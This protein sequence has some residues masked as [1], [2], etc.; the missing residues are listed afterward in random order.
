VSR[1]GNWDTPQE[2]AAKARERA[3]IEAA[4]AA[5]RRL[6][7]LRATQRLQAAKRLDAIDTITDA[8]GGELPTIIAEALRQ[9][10]DTSQQIGA[11]REL[12]RAHQTGQAGSSRPPVEPIATPAR[13]PATG[14]AP[15]VYRSG[16]DREAVRF[17]PSFCEG[18]EAAP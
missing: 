8:L 15:S 10:I 3:Q 18:A 14:R 11:H 5:R 4:A 1:R 9:V 16:I 17:G 12:I 6:R 7:G 13:T 2:A